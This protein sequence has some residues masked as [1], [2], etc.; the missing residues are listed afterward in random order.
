MVGPI[1]LFDLAASQA[2]W[3]ATRQ[4]TIASNVANAN[5]PGYGAIDVVPFETTL[6]KQSRVV[7]AV[8]SPRH[9]GGE[10]IT[11]SAEKVRRSE[12]WDVVHS[13]NTVSV[14][15]EM[16]KAGD[17]NRDFSLNT[18]IVKSFHRMFTAAAKA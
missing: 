9:I 6:D 10:D 16:L 12:S 2:R 7:P 5:T 14:E 15:Q 1:F 18:A 3:L 11:S 13:G 8:T 17:V 4:A